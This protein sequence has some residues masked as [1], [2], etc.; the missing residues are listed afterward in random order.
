VYDSKGN[1]EEV[2]FGYLKDRQIPTKKDLEV[3]IQKIDTLSQNLD[4]LQADKEEN[5]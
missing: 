1:I 5:E 2:I 4:E 3:L